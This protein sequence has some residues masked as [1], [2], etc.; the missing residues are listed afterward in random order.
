M[1]TD[2][3]GTI[4]EGIIRNAFT[5]TT[6][7]EFYFAMR[8][9]ASRKAQTVHQDLGNLTE[10]APLPPPPSEQPD[11]APAPNAS[12]TITVP[13]MPAPEPE[14]EPEAPPPPAGPR[15][16]SLEAL[17]DQMGLPPQPVAPVTATAKVG[18]NEP[19]PCGSGKKYKNCCGK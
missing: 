18:R 6:N 19:C 8:E 15:Q 13:G 9:R 14:P 10:A 5:T 4:K 16:G 3:M 12:F 11:P 2:L 1:F 7:I 17:M